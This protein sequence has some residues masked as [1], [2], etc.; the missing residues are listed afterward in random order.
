[1]AKT[2]NAYISGTMTGSI[3]IP[4]ANDALD[5]SVAK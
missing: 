3:E 5:K 4:T 2:G 1:M